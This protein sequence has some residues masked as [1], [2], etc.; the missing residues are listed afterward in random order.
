MAGS[1]GRFCSPSLLCLWV[2]RVMHQCLRL[3]RFNRW[4]VLVRVVSIHT[5]SSVAAKV[6]PIYPQWD[7]YFSFVASILRHAYLF[8]P[9]WS[10]TT[11]RMW[12]HNE[13]SK[14]YLLPDQFSPSNTVPFPFLKTSLE[15]CSLNYTSGKVFICVSNTKQCHAATSEA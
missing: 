11:S 10:H 6:F 13:Y 3:L 12:H 15:A 9:F 5:E 1:S 7:P 4:D 2:V 8:A 14:H